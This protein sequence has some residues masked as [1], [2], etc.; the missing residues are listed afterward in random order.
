MFTEIDELK[1]IQD[2]M[3]KISRRIEA[4]EAKAQDVWLM[5]DEVKRSIPP[6]SDHLLNDIK[7][8]N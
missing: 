3:F 7:L 5:A 4:A 8:I 6:S 1:L 2:Q